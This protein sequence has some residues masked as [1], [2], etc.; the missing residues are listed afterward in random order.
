MQALTEIKTEIELKG[1]YNIYY[2]EF[3]KYHTH[4]TETHDFW[5]MVYV[6]MGNI[7]AVTDGG[8]INLEQGQVI[9]RAPGERHA[10]ISNME[11]SNNLLVVSFSADGECMNFFKTNKV[12]TLNKSFKTLLSLFIDEANYALNGISNDF[13]DIK[14][15]DFS[16]EKFASSQLMKYHFTE[17]LI[18]LIRSSVSSE[19]QKK[20]TSKNRENKESFSAEPIAE[21]LEQNVYNSITLNDVCDKF[22]IRKSQLSVIFKEYSGKSP[23]KYFSDLKIFEAKKL[24]RDDE[25]TVSE[26]SEKLNFSCIHSFSRAFKKST[27][28]SP[29]DY[30]KSISSF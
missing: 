24:L 25:L 9:F 19:T 18:K 6:D 16:G 20:G 27:G 5:E 17:F 11:D 4:P 7:I 14:S 21:F 26:I 3:G 13:S 22:F 1:F 15:L 28:F 30:K 10:H 2:F 23:M 12:F 8:N 29:M